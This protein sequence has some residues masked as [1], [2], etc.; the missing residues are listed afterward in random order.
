MRLVHLFAAPLLTA[1]LLWS[2]AAAAQ[3]RETI[4]E[5]MRCLAISLAL[6]GDHNATAEQRNGATMS[7]LYF[8]GRVNARQP[9][10]NLTSALGREASSL[11]QADVTASRSRCGQIMQTRARELTAAA[12]HLDS[13]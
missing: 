10:L 7:S 8:L 6:A 11:T 9:D 3:P 13:H 2:T 12:D 4:A 5:D 1:S